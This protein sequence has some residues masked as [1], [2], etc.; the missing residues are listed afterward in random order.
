M[1]FI[2]NEKAVRIGFRCLAPLF[3][4]H[5]IVLIHT[6]PPLRVA[7]QFGFFPRTGMGGICAV[8]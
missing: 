4:R 6:Q 8:T 1:S 7:A 5:A 3:D 2:I